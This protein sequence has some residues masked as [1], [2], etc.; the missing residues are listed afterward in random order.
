MDVGAKTN[1]LAIQKK[2]DLK[3][4]SEWRSFIPYRVWVA[5]DY[6]MAKRVKFLVEVFAD[7][8]WRYV[9][10]EDAANDYFDNESPGVISFAAGDY[11]PVDIDLGFLVAPTDSFRIGL[12]FQNPYVT[13]YWKMLQF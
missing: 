9:K 2:P 4:D 3:A 11:R 5:L 7:N 8:G 6:D 12:H 13:F 1:P 10:F